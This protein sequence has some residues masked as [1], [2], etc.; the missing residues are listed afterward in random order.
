MQKFNSINIMQFFTEK[1]T[2]ES[3]KFK[4]IPKHSKLP[5]H[6]GEKKDFW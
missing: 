6:T 1:N 2:V 5:I 4:N 3:T